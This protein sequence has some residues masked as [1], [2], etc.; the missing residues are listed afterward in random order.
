MSIFLVEGFDT[1]SAAQII[2]TYPNSTTYGPDLPAGRFGG[3]SFRPGPSNQNGQWSMDIPDLNTLTIGAALFVP[4][5]AFLGT[6]AGINVIWFSTPADTRQFSVGFDNAGRVL[7]G[8]P[9]VGVGGPLAQSAPALFTADTWHYIEVELFVH[10]TLGVCRVWL[11]GVK[12][13]DVENVDTR[14]QTSSDMVRRVRFTIAGSGEGGLRIDDVYVKNTLTAL[15]PQR[16]ETLRP[17]A[18]SEIG[19]T[20][21][22]GT[23]N[24]SRVADSTSDGDTTHVSASTPGVRDRY[25]LGDLSGIPL[26]ISAVVPVIVARM[27]DTGPR[28]VKFGVRSGGVDAWSSDRTMAASY[29]VFSH[30]IENDPNTAAPWTPIAINALLGQIE[31]A[32]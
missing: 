16:V 32:S 20:R 31:V 12:V 6:G 11:N 5:S 1:L 18:D 26:S 2:A 28:Q 8:A 22:A 7:V 21:N 10:D 15:G 19:W 4:Q 27:D 3:N 30:V 13:I 25:A 29:Q 17:V 14:G 24:F 9:L 23:T